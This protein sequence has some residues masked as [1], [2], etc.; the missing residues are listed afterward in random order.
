MSISCLAFIGKSNEPMFV[1]TDSDDSDS[2]QLHMHSIVHC[3]LDILEERKGKKT[4]NTSSSSTEMFLGQ[5]Y[6]IEDFRVFGYC[7]NTMVKI[8]MVCDASVKDTELIEVFRS[9]HA[10]YVLAVQNPFQ[11]VGQPVS[12]L[13]FQNK[14]RQTIKKFN[15]SRNQRLKSM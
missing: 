13:R 2:L 8:M 1:Y 5:L 14:L 12:S 15:S 11:L 7:T 9:F 10:E 6:A 4:S 3:A